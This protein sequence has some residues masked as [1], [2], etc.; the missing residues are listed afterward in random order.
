[1]FMWL[2]AHKIF[3]VHMYIDNLPNMYTCVHTHKHTH[4]RIHLID[5]GYCQIGCP[6]LGIYELKDNVFHGRHFQLSQQ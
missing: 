1:M 3:I 6:V 5:V 4:R 2:Q